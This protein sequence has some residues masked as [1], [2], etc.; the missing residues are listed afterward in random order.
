MNESIEPTHAALE[1]LEFEDDILMWGGRKVTEIA[2]EIGQTPFYAY[3][4]ARMD[5]RVA[6]VSEDVSL[7]QFKKLGVHLGAE[8]SAVDLRH[9]LDEEAQQALRDALVEHEVLVFRGQDISVED[10]IRFGQYFGDLSVHPIAEHD[11]NIP[12]LQIN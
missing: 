8:V 7:P 6:D 10:Q 4:R 12:E 5:Q 2:E 9:S 11:E 3:D 1:T